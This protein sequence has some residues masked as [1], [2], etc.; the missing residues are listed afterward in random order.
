MNRLDE[1]IAELCPNGVEYKFLLDVANVL[2]GY[3]CDATQ[4]NEE[5]IGLPLVRIRDVLEGL[6]KTFTTEKIPEQYNLQYG[7]LLVGM[8]WKLENG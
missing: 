1:L 6:T 4:F 2:Y 7:D 8:D 5:G 3:P